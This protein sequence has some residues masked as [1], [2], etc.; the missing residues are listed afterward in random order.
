MIAL[1]VLIAILVLVAFILLVMILALLY[2]I[3]NG[4]ESLPLTIDFSSNSVSGRDTLNG[5][6][7]YIIRDL[8][9][10]NDV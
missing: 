5:R 3:I 9:P 4:F 6:D 2:T 10:D 1:G 7:S 8:N